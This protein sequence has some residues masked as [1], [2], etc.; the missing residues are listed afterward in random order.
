MEPQAETLT[1][2]ALCLEGHGGVA[3]EGGGGG[4]G[5][6]GP[7]VEKD[8]HEGW[9]REG[10]EKGSELAGGLCISEEQLEPEKPTSLQE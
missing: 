2:V 1:Q 4:G 10:S 9:G 6:C 7:G 5:S 3:V 8:P